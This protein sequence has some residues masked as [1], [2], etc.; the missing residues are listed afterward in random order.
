MT[1][2]NLAAYI[3]EQ[4]KTN[5]STLTDTTLSIYVNIAKNEICE[6]VMKADEDYFGLELSRNLEA[7]IRKYGIDA[8]VLNGIKYA[9]AKIDGVNQKR[10]V[11]YNLNKMGIATDEAS[12]TSFMAGRPWGYFVYG[13]Q[14]YILSEEAIIDVSAGLKLWAN[15]Y[16]SDIDDFTSEVD[17]SEGPS[18]IEFGVPLILHELIAR[19]AI[20]EYKNSQEKPIPLNEKE[21]LFA[22][23]LKEKISLLTSFNVDED[24]V[25][26]VPYND[27]SDF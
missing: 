14:L 13:N 3:R 11:P 7:G 5:S 25:P 22:A 18:E 20:I 23:D 1:P 21:Q 12:I 6:K 8:T 26:A 17:M 19:R 4:T 16:P 15:V 24:I 9:E 27:G 2:K 10:L